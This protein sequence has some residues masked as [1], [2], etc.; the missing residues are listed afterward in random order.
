MPCNDNDLLHEGTRALDLCNACGY[1]RGYCPVFDHAHQRE[2]LGESDLFYLANLCHDCGACRD[3]CQYA[4]PHHFHIDIPDTLAA[5]RQLSYRRFGRPLWVAERAWDVNGWR[6]IRWAAII[7]LPMLLYVLSATADPAV[8]QSFYTVLPW[9]IMA[10][11]GGLPAVW[12]FYA[13]CASLSA[14]RRG[15]TTSNEPPERHRILIRTLLDAFAWRQFGRG[16]DS[17]TSHAGGAA[18]LRKYLHLATLFGFAA[19]A[20]ASFLAAIY[21]HLLGHE[22][23]YAFNSIPVMLGIAGGSGIV[24]GSAGMI[25]FSAR[26]GAWNRTDRSFV[27]NLLLVAVSGFLLLFLRQTAWLAASLTLHLAAVCTFFF[28]LPYGQFLHGPFRC[29]AMLLAAHEIRR[30]RCMQKLTTI[31]Q[32]TAKEPT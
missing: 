28:A 25:L 6:W 20:A 16:N 31:P 21:Q 24:T 10:L 15:M 27:I 3:A 5:L 29:A 13:I 2:Q 30:A 8:G 14:F 19:C 26:R 9:P 22:A 17:C 11:I 18:S 1:C 32:K 23:P 7:S 4:P 12:A